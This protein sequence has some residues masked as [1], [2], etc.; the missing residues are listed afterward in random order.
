MT[1][2]VSAVETEAEFIQ[3]GLE[4]GAVAMVGTKE[5]SLEIADGFV[6]PL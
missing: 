3:I 6:K 1:N 4:F 5:K 2:N